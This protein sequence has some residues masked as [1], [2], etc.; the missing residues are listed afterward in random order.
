MNRPRRRAPRSGKAKPSFK[1]VT[2]RRLVSVDGSPLRKRAA[3]EFKGE[4]AALEKA[5]AELRRFET[6]ERPAFGAW[7]AATFGALL[8]ELRENAREIEE[9]QS[10]LD[11]VQMAMV[12]EGYS[13]PRKAYAEV[14]KR[15]NNP[16]PQ[17][18][19]EDD[20]FG[21][22]PGDSKF[23]KDGEPEYDPDDDFDF[24]EEEVLEVPPEARV[25]MFEDFVRG[26][27]GLN[28]KQIPKTTYDEMFA[29]FEADMFGGLPTGN[30]P[31]IPPS[32]DTPP[33]H[34]GE[35]RIKEIYRILVRRLHP[36]LRADGDTGVSGIWH[37][38]Q[39]AY[40]ARNLQRLETLLALTEM[41]DGADGAQ[42]TLGQMREAIKELQRAL[43]AVQWSIREAKHDPAWGFTGK[44]SVAQEKSIR[45][46]MEDDLARQRRALADLNR[47]LEDWSRPVAPKK[48]KKKAQKSAKPESPRRPVANAPSGQDDTNPF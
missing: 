40:E 45:R 12:W 3:A 48:R 11:E 16:E 31:R 27:L 34:S 2:D 42:T 38:V 20:F 24:F 28:P 41:G 22:K 30:P 37:E 26:V 43:R 33:R 21:G 44:N 36:D 1:P 6:K 29:Q 39:E 15:R 47:I 19:D 25:A 23:S 8:T 17:D 13:N 32:F 18:D 14:M 46:Q 9:K 5:R 7:L 35:G 10:L 4:M